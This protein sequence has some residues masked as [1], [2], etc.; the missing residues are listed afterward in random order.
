MP[1]KHTLEELTTGGAVHW[2]APAFKLGLNAL[3][4][5]FKPALM[6]GDRIYQQYNDTG[7][8]RFLMSVDYKTSFRGIYWFGETAFSGIGSWATINGLRWGNSFL[9]ACLLYR[10]YDKNI[11]PIMLPDLANIPIHPMRRGCISVPIYLL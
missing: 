6:I 10:R 4:Y 3:Y 5:D 1:E 2:N 9:S 11:S 7:H 8:K